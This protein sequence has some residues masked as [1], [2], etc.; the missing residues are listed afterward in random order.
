[1]ISV[2]VLS[3]K[4]LKGWPQASKG[5]AV[6]YVSLAK[7]MTDRYRTDAHTA[8][9]CFPSVERRLRVELLRDAT[10]RHLVGAGV[11]M[12]VALF[13]VDC[14]QSHK[15][16]G[17]IGDEPAPD[18]W[19]VAET[20]KIDALLAEHPGA[21]V[22]RTRGGYRIV[23]ELASPIVLQTS[24]DDSA[25]RARYSQ[26]VAYLRRRFS[27]F[28]DP[29]CS[30][31]TRLYRLPHAARA[32]IGRP[33]ERETLG[34]AYAIG[35]WACEPSA[36]DVALAD[37][38]MKRKPRKPRDESRPTR[39]HV[40]DC[41][42]EGVL[43]F[44]LNA[45]GE[46]GAALE[47]GKWSAR[48]PRQ[49]QHSKGS[50]LDGSTILYAPSLDDA[51]VFGWLHCSHAHC[52]TLT[53]REVLARFDEE[54]IAAARCAAG[55][56]ATEATSP[57]DTRRPRIIVSTEERE[58]ADQAIDA[59]AKLGVLYQRGSRLVDPIFDPTTTG[60]SHIIRETPIPRVRELL[61]D[62]ADWFIQRR[63]AATQEIVTLPAHPP[64]W[65]VSAVFYR[66]QWPGVPVL[67]GISRIP[68][69]RRDGSV[70][71][72]GYDAATRV[73]VVPELD[74]PILEEPTE[75]D[76]R[77]ALETLSEP[78][79][80]FPFVEPECRFVP[81]AGVLTVIGR[82]MIDGPCP[83]VVYES[84]TPGTGKTLQDNVCAT[85][86][87]GAPASPMSYSADPAELEKILSSYGLRGSRT[88]H[89]DNVNGVFG[90]GPLDKCIT[91]HATVDLRRLGS[92]SLETVPWR[93]VF[94]VTGNNM[95]INDDTQRRVIV[96]RIDVKE[97]NPEERTR[98][99][100]PNLIAW[101]REHRAELLSA[102][103][104][105]LRAYH[106]AGRPEVACSKLG[107]FDSW[108]SL[109]PRAI[110]YAGGLDLLA[111]R[112]EQR[113][114]RSGDRGVLHALLVGWEALADGLPMTI[115]TVLRT[116]YP[117]HDRFH[118]APPDAKDFYG[119]LRETIETISPKRGDRPDSKRLGHFIAGKKNRVIDGRMFVRDA[120]RHGVATWLVESVTSRRGE[121]GGSTGS[122][123]PFAGEKSNCTGVD[124][125]KT[126]GGHEVKDPHFP[127]DPPWGADDDP[128]A[129][130]A[131]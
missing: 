50:P 117:Q 1:M 129:E 109:I 127:P 70:H 95:D 11:S 107:G 8:A 125:H 120:D 78:F 19:W 90:G 68:I 55:L 103:F 82:E 64:E 126:P 102:G 32:E 35:A 28:A 118:G 29:S 3:N 111:A 36:E 116:L 6:P 48:C 57:R 54:E 76:A 37:T 5:G 9:Y 88:I 80:D 108:S 123:T 33:E 30:E 7:A 25:W 34:D 62:A 44:L 51:E 99:A 18:A 101:T 128:N 60:G 81:I 47:P 74:V 113:K 13:D 14:E 89:L 86:Y 110:V 53:L 49:A 43:Y 105:I 119:A 52:Q 66:G 58:I 4:N 98:F 71:A 16:S 84:S 131:Q 104:T 40:P 56:P 17:A 121:E 27:I 75:A 31:W 69:L 15:A 83:A 93:A 67:H 10:N 100:H 23:Y 130:A 96:A 21:F 72:A 2:P 42:G 41:K 77:V 26:W 106:L 94:F 97:E 20:E 85:I 112:R 92:S 61:A 114:A 59:L 63:D 79:R 73:L 39:T 91:A 115:G 124:D 24:I 12:V 122:S 65:A 87:D 22:Y 45:R 46:I 38:M